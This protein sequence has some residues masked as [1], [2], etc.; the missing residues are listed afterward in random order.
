[1]A[2]VAAVAVAVA[3]SIIDVVRQRKYIRERNEIQI[4]LDVIFSVIYKLFV[5]LSVWYISSR[6]H[7]FVSLVI[8]VQIRF[9]WFIGG[10]IK[11]QIAQLS[12]WNG[13]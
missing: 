1:M 8:S 12:V 5:S 10:S 4:L 3:V 6:K 7:L 2:I 11:H 9:E 13:K